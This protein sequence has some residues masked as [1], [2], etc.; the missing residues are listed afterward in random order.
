MSH[1]ATVDVEIRDLQALAA[2]CR[3]IGLELVEGQQ[4]YRWFGRSVGDYPL[5]E[6]M[7]AKDLGKCEHAI[8]IPLAEQAQ[9]K[10][11]KPYEIGVVRRPDGRGYRLVWDFWQ[12]GFGIQKR[13]GKD[14]TALVQSYAVVVAMR[15]AQRKGYRVREVTR[16]D[17]TVSLACDR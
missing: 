11:G 10:H 7:T 3:R 4:T 15:E 8:R 9:M 12:G 6:G 5:P 13:A 17:G 14:C 2:A 16:E 1:V